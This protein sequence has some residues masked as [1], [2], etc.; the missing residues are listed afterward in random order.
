MLIENID[1]AF[2]AWQLPWATHLSFDEFCELILPYRIGTEPLQN[3]RKEFY[4]RNIWIRDSIHD[5]QDIIKA[6]CMLNDRLKGK[7]DYRHGELDFYPG[8]LDVERVEKFGGGRCEDL[9]MYAGYCMRAVGIPIALE[10]TPYWSNSNYGG[11]SWLGVFNYTG[12]FVP[13]NS[14]YDNPVP[15]SLPFAG[16]KLAKAYRISFKAV[17]PL[18]ATDD[19]TQVPHFF[20]NKNYYDITSE[21]LPSKTIKI[22]LKKTPNHPKFAFLGVLNGYGW[23]PISFGSVQR[24]SALFSNMALEVIYAPLYYFRGGYYSS[25]E[26]LLAGDAFFITASGQL[27]ILRPNKVNTSDINF[28]LQRLP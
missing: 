7:Y 18:I 20:R 24:D 5:K 23:K 25:D 1:Y 3:W 19:S 12:K 21:Y 15:D 4:E 2:K 14:V 13:F 6:C 16:T 28:N 22:G 11:H 27:Q 9:N 10:F 17:S 8:M 26:F